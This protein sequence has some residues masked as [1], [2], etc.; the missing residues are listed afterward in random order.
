MKK[1]SRRSLRRSMHELA[2]SD[3]PAVDGAFTTSLE[4]RL[5][6]LSQAAP[7][8]ALGSNVRS[9]PKRASRAVVLGLVGATLTAA[10]AAAVAVVVTHNPDPPHPATTTVAVTT[11]I[12][13][14]TT[15]EATTT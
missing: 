10:G 14:T 3:T 5:R 8:S 15:I 4:Q 7:A 13:P 2:T 12:E 1:V 6:S 9:L 11:P